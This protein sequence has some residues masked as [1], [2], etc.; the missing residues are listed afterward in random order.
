METRDILTNKLKL[1]F[2]YTV[3]TAFGKVRSMTDGEGKICLVERDYK[4]Q[5]RNIDC[6]GGSPTTFTS[7][8]RG[9]LKAVS[10]REGLKISLSYDTE[11]GLLTSRNDSR[12]NA[13]SFKYDVYGRL[14]QVR[15]EKAALKDPFV[16]K[17]DLMLQVLYPDGKKVEWSSEITDVARSI[18]E[19][20]LNMGEAN[21]G[22]SS[23]FLP[24]HSSLAFDSRSGVPNTNATL[25]STSA[26]PTNVTFART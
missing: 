18:L 6:G 14:S 25:P 12:G 7:T 20:T 15:K 24:L 16:L 4:G 17:L 3:E 8:T 11:S 22:K 1:K 23:L 26:K 21:H 13:F 10:Y 9:W 19:P 5:V 2:A